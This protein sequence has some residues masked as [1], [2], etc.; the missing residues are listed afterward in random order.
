MKINLL[1]PKINV[2]CSNQKLVDWIDPQPK[3]N[4]KIN[5]IIRV[6]EPTLGKEEKKNVLDCMNTGWISSHGKYIKK[7]EELFAKK[8]NAKYAVATSSG[9][10][11]IHLLGLKE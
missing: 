3:K 1:E 10:T 4:K 6:C 9:S 8:C 11:A 7:F 5:G 2:K